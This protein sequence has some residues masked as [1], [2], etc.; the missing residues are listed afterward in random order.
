M[1]FNEN[2]VL[3]NLAKLVC[4]SISWDASLLAVGCST[5][6]PQPGEYSPWRL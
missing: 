6:S 1:N 3:E 5:P 4:C 2:V